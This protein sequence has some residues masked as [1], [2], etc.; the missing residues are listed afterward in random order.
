[1]NQH[2]H[3]GDAVAGAPGQLHPNILDLGRLG[4]V[5]ECID[6]AS[7]LAWALRVEHDVGRVVR[8]SLLT[9]GC[10][11]IGSEN[12]AAP[13]QI[14]DDAPGH[15]SAARPAARLVSFDTATVELRGRIEREHVTL[16]AVTPQGEVAMEAG[17]T[18][19]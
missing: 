2:R 19:A 14:L 11:V 16:W 4:A 3:D 13:M 7:A 9:L 15:R 12:V 10:T 1:M 5:C 8:R 17:A 18:L 6:A